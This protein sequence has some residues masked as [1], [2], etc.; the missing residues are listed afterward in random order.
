MQST[1]IVPPLSVW[2]LGMTYVSMFY[3][4]SVCPVCNI[5]WPIFIGSGTTMHCVDKGAACRNSFLYYTPVE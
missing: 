1:R 4:S 2:T 5:H 3:L